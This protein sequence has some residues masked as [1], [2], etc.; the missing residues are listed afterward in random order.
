[1]EM[2]LPFKILLNKMRKSSLVRRKIVLLLAKMKATN[3]S[4]LLQ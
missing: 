3:L 2:V 4:Y 1:M